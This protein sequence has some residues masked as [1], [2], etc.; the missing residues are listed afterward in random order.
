MVIRGV[1][2]RIIG[3][4]RDFEDKLV[5]I[6]FVATKLQLTEEAVTVNVSKLKECGIVEREGDKIMLTSIPDVSSET[7]EEEED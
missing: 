3:V 4:L 6:G 5:P 2:S 7:P 1:N